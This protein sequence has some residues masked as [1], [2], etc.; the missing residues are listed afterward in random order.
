M[1][2]DLCRFSS[3]GRVSGR[4]LILGGAR[5]YQ[6]RAEE[7]PWE[8][9]SWRDVRARS[10]IA[11]DHQQGVIIVTRPPVIGEN[12]RTGIAAASYIHARAGVG[13][14]GGQTRN[15]ADRRVVVRDGRHGGAA[16]GAGAGAT[17]GTS[18][19]VAAARMHTF[20]R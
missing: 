6:E 17:V 19:A 1:V 7:E 11:S 9:G 16:E 3:V 4:P 2:S 12:R 15:G 5:V 13:V 10:E 20:Y 18:S 8:D 14:G